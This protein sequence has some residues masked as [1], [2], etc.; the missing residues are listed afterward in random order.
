MVGA[1]LLVLSLVW[2]VFVATRALRD[3]DRPAWM[4]AMHRWFSMLAAWA[5]AAHLLTLVLD[6]YVH[7]GWSE[8]FLPGGSDWKRG[9]VTYGV[10]ALYLLAVVQVTS[11]LMRRMSRRL[12]KAVHYASYVAVWLVSIHGATAGTDVTNRVYA[13][14]AL[15]LTFLCTSAAVVR[16][17]FGTTRQQA[18]RR[19]LPSHATG[20]G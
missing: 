2:G 3:I 1:V 6:N 10:L 13:A 8:I 11:L 9:P 5:I 14:V 12:W 4:L 7:F 20:N 15:L 19:R 17:M 18:A 16:V